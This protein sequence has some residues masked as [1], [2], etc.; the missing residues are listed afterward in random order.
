MITILKPTSEHRTPTDE[1]GILSGLDAQ[2]AAEHGA[3]DHAGAVPSRPTPSDGFQAATVYA[4]LHGLH[5]AAVASGVRHAAPNALVEALKIQ[6]QTE[7]LAEKA[8]FF[9][10]KGENRKPGGVAG[11][12][13]GAQS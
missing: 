13:S 7:A 8:K 12:G 11:D 9:N 1:T 4:S 3:L 10:K 5:S 6:A 2:P